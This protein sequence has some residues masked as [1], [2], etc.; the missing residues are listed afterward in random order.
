MMIIDTLTIAGLL[1]VI[2]ISALVLLV[3]R[4][5]TDDDEARCGL[6]ECGQPVRR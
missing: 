5:P 4:A 2:S 3:N 6:D 1:T